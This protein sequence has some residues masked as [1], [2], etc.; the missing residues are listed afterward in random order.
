M[1]LHIHVVPTEPLTFQQWRRLNVGKNGG[2]FGS[3]FVVG[4][5]SYL[6]VTAAVMAVCGDADISLASVL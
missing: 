1:R 5:D 3:S 4:L 6:Y 2:A